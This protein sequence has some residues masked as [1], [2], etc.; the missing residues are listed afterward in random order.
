MSRKLTKMLATI[1]AIALMF[2]TT[3]YAADDTISEVVCVVEN[4]NDTIDSLIANAIAEADSVAS[5]YDNEIA[6]ADSD[7]TKAT[8]EAEK[9]AAIQVIA[10]GLMSNTMNLSVDVRE[11]ADDQGVYVICEYVPVTLGGIVFMIDPL[12]VIG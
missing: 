10:S 1:F 12:K 2:S 3:T 5:Y 11:F 6:N 7:E 4:A 8:L 9:I